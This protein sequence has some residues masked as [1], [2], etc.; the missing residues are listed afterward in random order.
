MK[1]KSICIDAVV[2]IGRIS[3]FYAA[4]RASA[5]TRSSRGRSTS[6]PAPR[7]SLWLPARGS[8][9]L[10]V[11]PPASSRPVFHAQAGD[12]LELVGVTH[13]QCGVGSGGGSAGGFQSSPARQPANFS[14]CPTGQPFS[15]TS[16]G[17]A[18]DGCA[19]AIASRTNR[20]SFEA[21][22]GSSSLRVACKSSVSVLMR[23][24]CH[25]PWKMPT[26]ESGQGGH[27]D[28]VRE[29]AQQ[30]DVFFTANGRQSTRMFRAEFPESGISFNQPISF[31][32]IRVHSRLKKTLA[33]SPD[34]GA[35][36]RWLRHRSSPPRLS[37]L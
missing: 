36:N 13:H 37:D 27:G 29:Q 19:S 34:H 4:P 3:T 30:P 35:T 2:L 7:R 17:F 11:R 33:C 5:S 18:F 9:I 12:A 23:Q 6:K 16:T 24:I 28:Q 10:T 26:A 15:S 20:S 14:K 1:T 21:E 22:S 31:A 32:F 8:G 25:M